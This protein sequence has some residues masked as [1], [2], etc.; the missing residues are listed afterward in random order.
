MEDESEYGY[1]D[2]FIPE[3]REEDEIS[4]DWV[5][6][7]VV[8]LDG[9]DVAEDVEIGSRYTVDPKILESLKPDEEEF[10]GWTGNEGAYTTLWYR[11]SVGGDVHGLRH[12]STD[13][14]CR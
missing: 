1:H 4:D 14:H 3:F 12:S 13:R 5:L 9:K 6:Q 10:S 8:A 2:D 11:R 7:K